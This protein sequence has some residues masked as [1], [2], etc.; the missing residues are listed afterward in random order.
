MP[1]TNLTT[2]PVAVEA[3]ARKIYVIRG[4]RVM[5]DSDLAELYQVPTFRLNESV[6]RN[7]ERF[8]EDFMFQLLPKEAEILTSKFAMSKPA[9]SGGRRTLPYA[10]T[11]QDVAMLSSVLRSPR[12]VQMNILIMRT[13]VKL[14]EVLATHKSVAQRLEQLSRAQK[15]HAARFEIVIKDIQSLDQRL[16]RQIRQLK[17]PRRRKPRIGFL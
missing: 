4:H 15:D 10:F 17:T 3:V 9:G 12:A 6:K 5:R 1:D 13:F 7:W 14:R 11:E 16:T 2:P 8:P